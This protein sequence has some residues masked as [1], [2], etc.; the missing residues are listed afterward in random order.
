MSIE[1]AWP[2][3]QNLQN[4]W[5]GSINNKKLTMDERP[6]DGNDIRSIIRNRATKSKITLQWKSSGRRRSLSHDSI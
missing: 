3:I 2:T 4:T 6:L 1:T 5:K